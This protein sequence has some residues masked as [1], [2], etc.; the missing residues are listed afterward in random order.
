MMAEKTKVLDQF[1]L[2]VVGDMIQ[3][4]RKLI[5]PSVANIYLA[6]QRLV[7]TI[8]AFAAQVIKRSLHE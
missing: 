2:H 7:T 6:T 8:L 3:M 1:V 5:P 4:H